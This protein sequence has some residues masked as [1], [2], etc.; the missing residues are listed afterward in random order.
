MLKKIV[1]GTL[2]VAVVGVLIGGAINRTMAKTNEPYG[3]GNGYRRGQSQV[4]SQT[5]AQINEQRGIGQ[6][7]RDRDREQAPDSEWTTVNATVVTADDRSLTVKTAD[8]TLLE[9]TGQAWSYAQAQG[10][11]AHEGDAITVSGWYEDGELKAG[12]MRNETT[13]QA[14][15][16]REETGRPLWAGIGRGRGR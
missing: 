11:S 9:I 4:N 14:I 2:L 8:G 12:Y 13:G 16:L 10:F 5:I 1:L 6:K 15:S 7:D 3:E